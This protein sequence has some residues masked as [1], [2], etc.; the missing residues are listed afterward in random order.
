MSSKSPRFAVGDTV[1]ERIA[2]TGMSQEIGTVT[3][4]YELGEDYRYVV[5]FDGGREEVF[6]EK[7]LL[8]FPEE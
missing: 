4:C 5:S 7:E 1:C 6:F 3:K 2:S 8:S